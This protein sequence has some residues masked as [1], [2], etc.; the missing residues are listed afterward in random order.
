MSGMIV[1]SADDGGVWEDTPQ[2]QRVQQLISSH[3]VPWTKTC[4]VKL[5]LPPRKIAVPHDHQHVT[6]MIYMTKTS[7]A[8]VATFLGSRFDELVWIKEGE[9]GSIGYEPHLALYPA[10][11]PDMQ[12]AEGFE[13]RND[14]HIGLDTKPRPE[15]W[16]AAHE[17][18]ID[19]GWGDVVS[20]PQ[21]ALEHLYRLDNGDVVGETSC[22]PT[23]P[24]TGQL[25]GAD[26]TLRP[27]GEHLS[28]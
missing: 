24:G 6:P 21:E 1:V 5:A 17:R 7:G 27:Y 19:L 20:W 2:G 12:P 26:I 25:L 28:G 13:I 18:V 3:N 23:L 10:L 11:V 14:R 9:W 22:F 15:M 8:G 16:K 4:V